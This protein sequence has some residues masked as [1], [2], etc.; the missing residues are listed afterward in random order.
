MQLPAPPAADGPS[1]ALRRLAWGLA[2]LAASGVLLVFLRTLDLHAVLQPLAHAQRGWLVLAVLANFAVLPL[3]T[4][5]C[6]LL[7]SR[8]RP[9]GWGR[10]WECFSLAVAGMNTLPFGGGHA[11]AVGLLATRGGLALDGALAL[12]ALEQFCEGVAKF[13]LL[14][15]ALAVLPLPAELQRST[16]FLGTVLFAG[17]AALL[18]LARRTPP[19]TAPTGWRARW[20]RHLTVLGHPRKLV[21]ALALALAG[22][23]VQLAAVFAV[24]RSLGVDLPLATLPLLLAAVTFATMISV[25]PG[26][27]VVYEAAAFGAYRWLGVPAPEAAALALVQHA[28][29]LG[30]MIVPGYALTAWRGLRPA[31]KT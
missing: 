25:A 12:M 18:W 8:D 4:T 17:G 3:L 30:P 29:F 1:R 14:L 11:L 15:L 21:S 5:E 20:S 10:L 31:Q 28:C 19:G 13:A 26:N 9:I 2:W 27:L 6:A 22:K 7:A 24:Q 16:W 23:L